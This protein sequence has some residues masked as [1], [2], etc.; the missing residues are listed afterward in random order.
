[1]VYALSWFVVA[2]LL[3]T[4]SLA[5]W[6]LHAVTVWS[7]AHAGALSSVA[8]GSGGVALPSWLAP[9]VP[10]ELLQVVTS[11]AAGLGP[12]V[13][14]LLQAA[15][16]LAPVL[17]VVAWVIWAVGGGLFLLLG[18]GL[19]WFM[20]RGRRQGGGALLEKASLAL[21]TRRWRGLRAQ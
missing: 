4:W 5:V 18:A 9:W 1:M 2:L 17:T 15:P 6:A 14:E 20:S 13:Q 19:T 11:L 3:A 8:L 16:A 12:L 10:P 21:A 7:V